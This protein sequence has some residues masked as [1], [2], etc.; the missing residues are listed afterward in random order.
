M[1]QLLAHTARSKRVP[2][3]LIDRLVAAVS[4]E[5]WLSDTTLT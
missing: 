3:E 2:D 1:Y 5:A 4:P